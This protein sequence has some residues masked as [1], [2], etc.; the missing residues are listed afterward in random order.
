MLNQSRLNLLSVLLVS[1]SLSPV[2]FAAQ[3]QDQYFKGQSPNIENPALNQKIRPLC[4]EGFAVM[5]S[6]VT[7]TPLW[8]GE[9]LTSAR[10][11]KA[12]A[13]DRQDSFH[14]E[15]ALPASER[16]TL[17]DYRASGYDR[18]HMAPNGDM[19]DRQQQGESFSLANMVPQSP[20]N[21]REVWR[22]LEEATRALVMQ[23][24]EAFV[25][26]GPAF[27]GKTVKKIKRVFVPSHV[28]KVVY[29]PKRQAASAYWAPNDESG[30]V[31]V[32]SLADLEQKIGI[33]ILP[34]VS[35]SVRK[36][37]VAL[38]I[39]LSAVSKS[40]LG[41]AQPST[42]SSTTQPTT[43]Q[44]ERTDAAAEP[45]A[46]TQTTDWAKIIHLIF[47]LFQK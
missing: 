2:V 20:T 3:C 25:V 44:P 14:E 21:N 38:P 30:T 9:R 36:R 42:S 47:S 17:S 34:S 35:D 23:E 4:F 46:P 27:L 11:K 15:E 24:G 18:G 26:T 12:R 33:R 13:L 19:A 43:N 40:T 28:Y 41:P 22:N 8:V 6:G 39:S 1:A 16:A 37:R 29:F 10:L 32:I 5:H 45:S 7:L 31:E